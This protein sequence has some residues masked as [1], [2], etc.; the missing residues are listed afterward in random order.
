MTEGRAT[1]DAMKAHRHDQ[2]V[3][4]FARDLSNGVTGGS[5]DVSVGGF[6]H[7]PVVF[8]WAAALPRERTPLTCP[9]A[10][11]EGA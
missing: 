11:P 8:V 4:E 9:F 7:A 5:T 6:W 1:A 3:W 10:S 2:E